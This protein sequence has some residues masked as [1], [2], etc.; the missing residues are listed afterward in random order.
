MSL[1][2]RKNEVAEITDKSGSP[3][4]KYAQQKALAALA[5]AALALAKEQE[6]KKSKKVVFLKPGVTGEMV[7]KE[8]QR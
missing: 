2:K 7:N 5:L 4:K 1:K 3:S 8:K 6:A